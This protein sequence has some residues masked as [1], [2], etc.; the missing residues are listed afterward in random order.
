[1]VAGR[2]SA[3]E[4]DGP[5]WNQL[6]RQCVNA[7]HS[8]PYCNQV[9]PIV[10]MR[11]NC[12]NNV[13]RVP[14]NRLSLSWFSFFSFNSTV[15]RI[16]NFPVNLPLRYWHD[17]TIL[18]KFYTGWRRILRD[19]PPFFLASFLVVV[20]FF[21]FFEMNVGGYFYLFEEIVRLWDGDDSYEKLWRIGE[22]LIFGS[23]KSL[24]CNNSSDDDTAMN[25]EQRKKLK[26]EN[27]VKLN[28]I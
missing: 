26:L 27:F 5:G 1:M 11:L 2:G 14:N 21:F 16:E 24:D 17:E 23:G 12:T 28:L 25:N 20:F 15:S 10:T 13:K 4:G 3:M 22:T 19:F 9:W 6:S 8:A 7:C 18:T